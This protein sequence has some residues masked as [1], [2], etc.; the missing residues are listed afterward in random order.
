MSVPRSMKNRPRGSLRWLTVTSV[1]RLARAGLASLSAAERDVVEL[2]VIDE[3]DYEEIGAR[4]KITPAAARTRV[5]RGLS[6]LG[7]LME[8]QS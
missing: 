4:L 6:R 7:Q 3:L 2:R 5:H 8:A 1:T